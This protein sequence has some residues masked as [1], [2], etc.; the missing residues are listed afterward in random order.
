MRLQHLKITKYYVSFPST[1]ARRTRR[2]VSPEGLLAPNS[3]SAEERAEPELLIKQVGPV[4]KRQSDSGPALVSSG[5]NCA[6]SGCRL[7]QRTA[8]PG[9]PARQPQGSL[10]W[11]IISPIGLLLTS[12]LPTSLF[13]YLIEVQLIYNVM[14][15]SAV[16]HM[17][18]FSYSFPLGLSQDIEYSSLCYTVEPCCL[19]SLYIIVCTC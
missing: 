14:L 13:I 15:I 2:G 16:I 6:A 7:S 18:S 17:Y 11:L 10:M 4:L 12:S 9:P 1:W 19:S 5:Y 3:V 8:Q